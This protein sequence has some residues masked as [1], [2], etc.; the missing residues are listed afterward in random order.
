MVHPLWIHYF[1]IFHKH[2]IQFT[3]IISHCTGNFNVKMLIFSFFLDKNGKKLLNSSNIALFIGAN[4]S[5]ESPAAVS[6]TASNLEFCIK[7]QFLNIIT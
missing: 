2:L 5:E 3:I 7:Q 1:T 4:L 6:I